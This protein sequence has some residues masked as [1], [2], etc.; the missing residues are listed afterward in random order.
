MKAVRIHNSGDTEVFKYEEKM[1]LRV[2]GRN[3]MIVMEKTYE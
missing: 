2:A 3:Q 1:I